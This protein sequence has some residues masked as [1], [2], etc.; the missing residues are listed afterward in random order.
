[1]D[2][3]GFI[4]CG[5]LR[6]DFLLQVFRI[7]DGILQIY[8]AVLVSIKAD[9]EDVE[10]GIFCLYRG[11]KMNGFHITLNSIAGIEGGDAYFIVS[12]N[13]I[14]LFAILKELSLGF[15]GHLCRISL[16]LYRYAPHVCI[17]GLAVQ[18][19]QLCLIRGRSGNLFIIAIGMD[20]LAIMEKPNLSD[21]AASA[22]YL[23][24]DLRSVLIA[25]R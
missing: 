3:P 19:C 18:S 17:D 4:Q 21:T 12:R 8:S 11:I 10:V 9:G 5:R 23:V 1:M 7:L 14:Y 2:I 20:K 24:A 15:C 13:G 6:F 25:S 16:V 22:F